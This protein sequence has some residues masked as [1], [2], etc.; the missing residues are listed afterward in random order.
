[1]NYISVGESLKQLRLEKGLTQTEVAKAINTTPGLISMY[2]GNKRIPSRNALVKLAELYEV[3]LDRIMFYV[4]E[5]PVPEKASD[6]EVDYNTAPQ[7][8]IYLNIDQL[9]TDTP[10]RFATTDDLLTDFSNTNYF[11]IKITRSGTEYWALVENSK[12]TRPHSTYLVRSGRKFLLI[13]T[14]DLTDYNRLNVFGIVK[15]LTLLT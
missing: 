13:K 14:E 15:S 7:I 9:C 8:P 3:G 1:M 5:P 4:E 12:K 10:E 11:Y 6:A 2:E